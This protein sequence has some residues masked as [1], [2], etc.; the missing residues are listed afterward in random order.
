M[1]ERNYNEEGF[2]RDLVHLDDETLRQELSGNNKLKEL[3]ISKSSELTTT[4][5]LPVSLTDLRIADCI[6]LRE[7]P[8]LPRNLKTL[9]IFQCDS[10]KKLSNLP[11]LTYLS[12][13]GCESLEEDLDLP[14]SLLYLTIDNSPLVNIIELPINMRA[15]TCSTKQLFSWCKKKIFLDS[16]KYL[17]RKD[18][19]EFREKGRYNH[20]SNVKIREEL[21]KRIDP[22]EMGLVVSTTAMQPVT[23]ASQTFNNPGIGPIVYSYMGSNGSVNADL[24]RTATI[25]GQQIADSRAAADYEDNTLGGKSKKRRMFKK[26]KRRK[27]KHTKKRRRTTKK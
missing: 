9:D 14:D 24:A 2:S 13:D 19:F 8:V 26:S 15:L 21:R 20:D 4:G 3:T 23:A 5:N 17:L 27:R 10:L 25:S 6:N 1:L 12:I 22:T 16:I 11:N 18:N 7:I